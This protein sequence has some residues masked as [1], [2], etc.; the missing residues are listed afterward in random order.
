MCGKCFTVVNRAILYQIHV[1][2]NQHGFWYVKVTGP[3]VY[4]YRMGVA[5][6]KEIASGE[7]AKKHVVKEVVFSAYFISEK[8]TLLY[9]NTYHCSIK[10]NGKIKFVDVSY[11]SK[12]NR[13][14]AA[15]AIKSY[16]ARNNVT[17]LPIMYSFDC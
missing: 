11:V 16:H 8:N 6:V 12:I 7:F 4:T 17:E 10:M 5:I 9:R 2:N 14:I 15:D 3:S 13:G 1:N